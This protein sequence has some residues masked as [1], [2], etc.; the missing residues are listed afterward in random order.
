M[1]IKSKKRPKNRFS[2]LVKS[3]ESEIPIFVI[4]KTQNNKLTT[5][6]KRNGA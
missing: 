5:R 2:M 6:S 1:P 3:Q 4:P